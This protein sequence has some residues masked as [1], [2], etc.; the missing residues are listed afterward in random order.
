MTEIHDCLRLLEGTWR[1]EE[2]IAPS[3]WTEA[4]TARASVVA[5]SVFGGAVLVQD[6]AS[7][8][9][10]QPWFSA[11]GVFTQAPEGRCAL[12]WFDSFGFAPDAP[13]EGEWTGEAL[14]FVRTSPRGQSRQV[15]SEIVEGS[16]SMTITTSADGGGT[17]IPVVSGRYKRIP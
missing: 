5:R 12:Y 14:V 8:R 17:W 9:D 13:A 2:T 11:H 7:E 3:R 16:Y 15:Y 4:G 10:G 6:S 1:G